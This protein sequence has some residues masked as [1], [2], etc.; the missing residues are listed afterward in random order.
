[1]GNSA[2]IRIVGPFVLTG[3][4]ATS[5]KNPIGFPPRIPHCS[6]VAYFAFHRAFILQQKMSSGHALVPPVR[7]SVD[8]HRAGGE[9]AG[10]TKLYSNYIYV[11]G[12]FMAITFLFLMPV[13]IFAS[14]F[15]RYK[16]GRRW[17]AVSF[18]L[19]RHLS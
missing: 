6:F 19:F 10:E 15:G 12:I 8:S 13:A 16:V 1:M 18:Y 2:V 17:L 4:H 9:S 3:R 14:R 5:F 11:H 7:A